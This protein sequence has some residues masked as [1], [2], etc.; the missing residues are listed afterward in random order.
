MIKA[1]V[2]GE[3]RKCGRPPSKG[4][5]ILDELYKN[6]IVLQ[7]IC[8]V[9]DLP[10]LYNLSVDTTNNLVKGYIDFNMTGL[11]IWSILVG[12]VIIY[13]FDYFVFTLILLFPFLI[14]ALIITLIEINY[15]KSIVVSVR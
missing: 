4:R 1:F 6:N 14:L 2:S 9:K 13:N 15:S 12:G 8:P 10:H 11:Y 3:C 7:F 5:F